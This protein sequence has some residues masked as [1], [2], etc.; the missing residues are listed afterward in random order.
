MKHYNLKQSSSVIANMNG[1]NYKP[2]PT[3]NNPINQVESQVNNEEDKNKKIYVKV[4]MAFSI[5]FLFI[6][7]GMIVFT[8]QMSNEVVNRESNYL[9]SLLYFE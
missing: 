1:T 8:L 9:F 6:C 5:C 3:N 2:V 7:I 4:I